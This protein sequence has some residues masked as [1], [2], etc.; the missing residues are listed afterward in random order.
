VLDFG[1]KGTVMSGT[2]PVLWYNVSQTRKSRQKSSNQLLTSLIT[3][4]D[5]VPRKM[6]SMDSRI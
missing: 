5:V 1:T 3:K 6:T 2:L 4:S